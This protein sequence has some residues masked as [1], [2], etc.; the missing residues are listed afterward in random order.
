M[1][2][3]PVMVPEVLR[4]LVHRDATVVLDATVGA[5]GHAAAILEACPHLRLIGIDRDPAA[6]AAARAALRPYGDRVSLVEAVYSDLDRVLGAAGKHPAGPEGKVDAVLMDLGVSSLQIDTASR[7][8]SYGANGPLSM[9]MGGAGG[10]ARLLIEQA[11][12][13]DLESILRRF[14]EVAGARRIARAIRDAADRGRMK[15]T[16]DLRAAVEG[17]GGGASPQL[18]SKV[19]QAIRIAVNDELEHLDRFLAG[20]LRHLKPDARVCVVSYHSLEDRRVKEFFKRESTACLCP[21]GVPVCVCGHRASLEVLTRKVVRPT[22]EEVA[23]NPRARSA[24]LRAAR[25]IG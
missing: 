9:Q 21:P 7:G 20:V 17:A 22:S 8:F 12:V 18:L 14:G 3:I 10:S 5:G 19:F 25:F 24:R 2:H 13:L 15:T 4:L 16:L 6:L 1:S 11:D 23:A